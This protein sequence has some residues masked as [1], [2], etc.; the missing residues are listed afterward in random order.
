MVSLL[1]ILCRPQKL[2]I[3]QRTQAL[4]KTERI[5]TLRKGLIPLIGNCRHLICLCIYVALRGGWLKK[6]HF[7]MYFFSFFSWGRNADKSNF[8]SN[9]VLVSSSEKTNFHLENKSIDWQTYTLFKSLKNILETVCI[10]KGIWNQFIKGLT[11]KTL[12]LIRWASNFTLQLHHQFFFVISHCFNSSTEK[13]KR[14]L[15]LKKS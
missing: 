10:Q 3:V 6:T 12:A 4:V 5:E 11:V 13:K 14:F 15:N 1:V 9:T 7:R 2:E 8:K